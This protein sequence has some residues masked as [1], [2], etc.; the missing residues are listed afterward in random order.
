MIPSNFKLVSFFARSLN[1]P[2]NYF[3]RGSRLIS[4]L[5]SSYLKSFGS[6][7]KSHSLCVTLYEY[8]FSRIDKPGDNL[9]VITIISEDPNLF[10]IQAEDENT[11]FEEDNLDSRR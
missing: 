7:L 2:L 5:E 11:E 4:T 3:I 6:S 10:N 9:E 1:K 8:D